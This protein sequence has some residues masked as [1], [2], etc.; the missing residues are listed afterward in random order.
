MNL[1]LW[2]LKSVLVNARHLTSTV[3]QLREAFNAYVFFSDIGRTEI[4]RV[5]INSFG[6]SFVTIVLLNN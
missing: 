6:L 5:L 3:S 2:L 4:I 1:L